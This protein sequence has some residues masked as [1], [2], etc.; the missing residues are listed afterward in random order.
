MRGIRSSQLVVCAALALVTC[1]LVFY[2]TAGTAG[3]RSR[4]D[5]RAAAI[6]LKVGWTMPVDSLNPFVG[7]SASDYELWALNYDSLTRPRAATMVAGPDLATSWKVSPNGETWTFHLRQGVKWQDGK[8]FT[9]ADVAWT[10]NFIIK[11]DVSAFSQ[12]IGGIGRVKAPTKSTVVFSCT[13][14][15]ADMLCQPIPILPKHIWAKLSASAALHGF[16]NGPPVVGTGPFQVK[17][18]AASSVKLVKNPHYWGSVQPAI[19]KVRFLSYTNEGQ[20]VDDLKSGAIDVA[21]GIPQGRF[22]EL[23]AD[24][25][26]EAIGAVRLALR[27]AGVQLLCGHV[28]A[29]QSGAARS[30]LPAGSQL[31]HRQAGDHRHGLR[32]LRTSG[33]HGGHQRLLPR[34]TR[35]ALVAAGGDRVLLRPGHLQCAARCSRLRARERRAHQQEGQADRL[36]SLHTIRVA[37][38]PVGGDHDRRSHCSRAACRVK[39]TVL[40]DGTLVRPS[41]QTPVKGK[42]TPDYDMFIWGWS[43]D[44]DPDFTFSVFT[45]RQIDGWSDCAYSNPTYDSLYKQQRGTVDPA[46]RKALTDQH[47][48]DPLRRFA[49]HPP[50]VPGGPA[51]VQHL[52]VGRLGAGPGGRWR[53]YLRPARSTRI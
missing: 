3:A 27:R 36:A 33:R 26:L 21:D 40:D 12:Y 49:I 30:G 35:L 53:R 37:A 7:F 24:P 34:C 52:E 8:P 28:L 11:H 4:R 5:P 17:S 44:W 31:G 45:T 25:D 29:G 15:K 18:R 51:G 2:I 47:A 20:M 16:K 9:A 32:R 22:A 42:F 23:T 10:Y 13:R 43:N 14:A 6:V 39:V 41:L 38:E 19:G 50:R 46:A 48:A 1:W